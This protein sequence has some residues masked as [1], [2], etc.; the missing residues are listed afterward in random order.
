M[1][2]FAKSNCFSFIMTQLPSEIVLPFRVPE[3]VAAASECG[4]EQ[5]RTIG[6]ETDRKKE[7]NEL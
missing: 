5:L 7:K 3:I 6:T 4:K 1:I 2:G